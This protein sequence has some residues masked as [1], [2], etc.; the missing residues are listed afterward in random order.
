LFEL[1]HWRKKRNVKKKA[2]FGILYSVIQSYNIKTSIRNKP[3]RITWQFESKVY[4]GT[5]LADSN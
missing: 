4:S 5:A 2:L 1:Q 3:C